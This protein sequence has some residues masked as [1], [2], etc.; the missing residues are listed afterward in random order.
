VLI[1]VAAGAAGGLMQITLTASLQKAPVSVLSPF[2]YLQ[3]VGAVVLGWLL[4]SE[5]PTWSTLAGAAL[6]VVSGLYIAWRER[7]LRTEQ[8]IAPVESMK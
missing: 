6:I 5:L 3:I 4:L 7:R 2:D 8:H 1:L